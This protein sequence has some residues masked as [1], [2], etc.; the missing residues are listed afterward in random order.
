V[1]TKYFTKWVEAIPLKKAT[2]AAI[3]NFIWEHIICRFGIPYKI[4]TD[5]GAPFI[6]KDVRAMTKHY[7]VKHLKSSH[8]IRKVTARLKQPIACSCASLVKWC[9]IM[10]RIGAF[11]SRMRCRPIG[12]PPKLPLASPYSCW[13][14]V[15]RLLPQ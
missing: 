1:A 7:H 2:C 5:N 11:I 4:V 14:M 13:S 3:A 9:S 12:H 6:N 15:Q 10:A 8:I